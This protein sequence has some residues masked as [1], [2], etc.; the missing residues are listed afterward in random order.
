MQRQ[1]TPINAGW[2]A[3]TVP[4]NSFFG[5]EMT[6]SPTASRFDNSISWLAAVGHEAALT[7][8][9]DFG[10]E[11]VYARNRE[12]TGELRAALTDAGCAPADRPEGNRST[13]VT[14]PLADREPAQVEHALSEQG[15]VAAVR[16]GQLRL[17]IHFYNHEDDIERLARKISR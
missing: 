17:S 8:F 10:P 3:G 4:L 7:V 2:K 6:L 11:V 9:D 12:L 5:P 14:I 15:I 16:D 1:F 13:I